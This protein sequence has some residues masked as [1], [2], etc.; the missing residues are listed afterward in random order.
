MCIFKLQAIIKGVD[1]KSI[2]GIGFGATCSLVV[3]DTHGNPVTVSP[4]HDPER[5]IIL[6]QDHRAIQEANEINELGHPLLKYVGGVISPEMEPPKLLWLK[7][8]LN[9]VCWSK[10]GHFF[11]LADYLVYRATDTPTRCNDLRV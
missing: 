4:S 2:K 5:N 3:V 10:A 9:E 1:P 7:K 8:H 11:D 6:W